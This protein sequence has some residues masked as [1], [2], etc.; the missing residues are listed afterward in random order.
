MRIHDYSDTSDQ[1]AESIKNVA[2]DIRESSSTVR[3]LIV[4]ILRSGTIEELT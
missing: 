3:E 1:A 2:K 4:T